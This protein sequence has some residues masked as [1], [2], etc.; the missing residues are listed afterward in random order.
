MSA[1]QPYVFCLQV[2][3]NETKSQ[4]S[5]CLHQ[6]YAPSRKL[7]NYGIMKNLSDKLNKVHLKPKGIS[8]AKIMFKEYSI[9][10]PIR[11][12]MKLFDLFSRN[13]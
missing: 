10:N 6:L 9:H 4:H 5:L 1:L 11:N 8:L 3:Y 12:H 2:M 13:K 7:G